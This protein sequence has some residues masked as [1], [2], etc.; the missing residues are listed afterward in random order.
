MTKLRAQMDAAIAKV[1]QGGSREKFKRA[2]EF[3][4][5]F[6]TDS[7]VRAFYLRE[8]QGYANL[9]YVTNDVLIDI[10]GREGEPG[11]VAANYC[12]V[13]DL[14]GLAAF[15]GS[16]EFV[17]QD[18]DAKLIVAMLAPSGMQPGVQWIAKTEQEVTLLLA[19][20]EELTNLIRGPSNGHTA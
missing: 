16:P 15:Q 17:P 2:L 5:H 19:F 11:L 10:E 1:I 7:V 8:D 14:G 3:A 4:S 13:I 9:A 18:A 6:T 20:V 12:P